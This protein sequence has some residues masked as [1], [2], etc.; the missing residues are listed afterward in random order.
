MA[1]PR[2]VNTLQNIAMKGG[3]TA[4]ILKSLCRKSY[5]IDEKTLPNN[6]P[7]FINIVVTDFKA[8]RS[9]AK[10]TR[11]I[12]VE[13]M[14]LSADSITGILAKMKGLKDTV[15]LYEQYA[16]SFTTMIN[17]A[18]DLA[19]EK[20]SL[21]I[22]L[23]NHTEGLHSQLAVALKEIRE[24]KS[25]DQIKNALAILNGQEKSLTPKIDK[26]EENV[27]LALRELERD[28]QIIF[29]N[30]RGLIPGLREPI[31]MPP[32]KTTKPTPSV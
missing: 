11:E 1:K 28:Y 19:L 25:K 30:I 26:L 5:S 20:E 29:E 2:E 22:G 4:D 18:R 10:L 21:E 17:K 24:G 12:G 23:K 7:A 16:Q 9:Q 8:A 15:S 13:Q 6:D 27:K 32:E 31:K 14:M 3:N